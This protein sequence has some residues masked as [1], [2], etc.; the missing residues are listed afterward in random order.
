[1]LENF[2]P[3]VL[4]RNESYTKNKAFP[5]EKLCLR[6]KFLPSSEE[7][8]KTSEPSLFVLDHYCYFLFYRASQDISFFSFLFKTEGV[9]LLK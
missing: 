1:M 5:V 8:L 3:N 2:R 7:L 4:N 9:P 6:S